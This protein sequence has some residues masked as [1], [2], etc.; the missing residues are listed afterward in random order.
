VRVELMQAQNPHLH[1][2]SESNASMNKLLWAFS[3]LAMI[4]ST[5]LSQTS[6]PRY[7]DSTY[8]FT[9]NPP[10]FATDTTLPADV[11]A[12]FFAP[13]KNGFASNLN[14]TIQNVI[15]TRADYLAFTKAQIEKQSLKFNT[16]ENISVSGRD[17]LLLDWEGKMNGHDVRCLALAV[18]DKRR[19]FLITGTAPIEDY[20]EYAAAFRAS[21]LSF[22]LP[23]H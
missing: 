19:V 10:S 18:F 16:S 14:I 5:A 7:V 8:G 21:L 9:M 15:T 2:H 13:S 17:A 1:F 12:M 22:R 23:A 11:T 3:I 4:S 6:H 20:S